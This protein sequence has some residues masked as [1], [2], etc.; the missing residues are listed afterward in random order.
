MFADQIPTNS[1]VRH[2]WHVSDE[3]V[4]MTFLNTFLAT[5]RDSLLFKKTQH[6]SVWEHEKCTPRKRMESIDVCGGLQVSW[7]VCWQ[8]SAIQLHSLASRGAGPLRPF[9]VIDSWKKCCCYTVVLYG[10]MMFYVLLCF[11]LVLVV[12]VVIM[13]VVF[14]WVAG[15]WCFAAR[16]RAGDVALFE[17]FC[18]C[19]RSSPNIFNLFSF[20]VAQRWGGRGQGLAHPWFWAG[21]A[22]QTQRPIARGSLRWC[23]TLA[24]KSRQRRKLPLVKLRA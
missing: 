1:T 4:N 15:Y 16:F 6:V 18:K 10:F 24:N 11:V 19:N 17:A 3:A 5:T 21:D 23:W 22:L 9:V 2:I 8:V 12:V 20:L 7:C 14:I 13:V